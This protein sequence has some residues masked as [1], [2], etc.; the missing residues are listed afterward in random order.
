MVRDQENER[1][2]LEHRLGLEK[3]KETERL[4]AKALDTLM[5]SHEI[6]KQ[7]LRERAL[8]NKETIHLLKK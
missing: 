1:M 2:R 4:Q 3:A 7:I 8:S 6:K 5:I